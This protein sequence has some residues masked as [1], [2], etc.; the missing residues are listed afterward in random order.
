MSVETSFF[1]V[2]LFYGNLGFIAFFVLFLIHGIFIADNSKREVVDA[3]Q[4]LDDD[5]D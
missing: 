4:K 3:F 5:S 2:I 1:N